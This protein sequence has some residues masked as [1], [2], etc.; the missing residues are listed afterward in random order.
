M[1]DGALRAL[2]IFSIAVALIALLH[3]VAFFVGQGPR[4][5]R[6]RAWWASVRCCFRN[7]M[8]WRGLRRW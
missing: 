7:E 1:L 4:A 8:I 2:T 6:M 5:K 3:F